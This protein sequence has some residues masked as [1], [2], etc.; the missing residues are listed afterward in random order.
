[1]LDRAIQTRHNPKSVAHVDDSDRLRRS[2]RRQHLPPQ[3]QVFSLYLLG[4]G[5]HYRARVKMLLLSFLPNLF[6]PLTAE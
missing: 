1:M 2:N 5:S 4:C 3:A 6:F